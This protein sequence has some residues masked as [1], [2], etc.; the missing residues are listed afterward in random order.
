MRER[1]RP[2]QDGY[3]IL[4]LT[5][6]LAVLAV[7]AGIGVPRVFEWTSALRVRMAASEVASTL[8]TA[9]LR[10]V[11]ERRNLA[12]KFRN[13]GRAGVTWTLYADGDGDGVKSRDI[14]RGIDPQIQQTRYLRHFGRRVRFGFPI[15]VRPRDPG[16]P[17]RRLDRL[18]DPIRFNRSDLASFSPLGSA[19]PG[20]VYITDG[21]RYL[22]AVR[23]PGASSRVR[24][25]FYDSATE[26]WRE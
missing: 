6:I 19:T 4:E 26:R 5:V 3:Q 24:I 10:S 13:E 11:H 14:E 12:V 2:N 15:G 16:N 7:G 25:L 1:N 21:H 8:Q 18:D 20:T 17:R 9:R 23:V 22:A